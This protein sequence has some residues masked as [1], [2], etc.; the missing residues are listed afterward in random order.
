MFEISS[1]LLISF[2]IRK[3]IMGITTPKVKNWIISVK[4][5]DLI[6]PKLE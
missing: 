6:P 1:T 3:T 2:Q 4:V 5:T